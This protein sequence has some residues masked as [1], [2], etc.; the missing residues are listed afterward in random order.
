[1]KSALDHLDYNTFEASLTQALQAAERPDG[2]INVQPTQIL[3][4]HYPGAVQEILGTENPFVNRLE[5]LRDLTSG[6]IYWP[7]P[8]ESGAKTFPTGAEKKPQTAVKIKA[9]MPSSHP[10]WEDFILDHI[11]YVPEDELINH[12]WERLP[13]EKTLRVIEK[14]AIRYHLNRLIEKGVL[15]RGEEGMMREI[16]SFPLEEQEDEAA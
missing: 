2:T 12:L 6:H 14:P 8:L 16:L 5:D 11:I 9:E 4:A 15:W 7:E 13:Q 10:T 1:M 3:L